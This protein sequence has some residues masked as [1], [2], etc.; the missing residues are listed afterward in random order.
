MSTHSV[1][2]QVE[3]R[4]NINIF[5]LKKKIVPYLE[6]VSRAVMI[7]KKYFSLTLSRVLEL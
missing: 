2:F 5:H 1:C 3:V 4:K 6:I 7:P